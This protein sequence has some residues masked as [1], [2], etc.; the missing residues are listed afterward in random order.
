MDI[1]M[2]KDFKGIT[3]LILVN[4]RSSEYFLRVKH[5]REYFDFDRQENHQ[6]IG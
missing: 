3:Q 4:V 1:F 2:K 5:E 6:L